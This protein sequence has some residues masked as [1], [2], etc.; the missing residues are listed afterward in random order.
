MIFLV[1]ID[2]ITYIT[3]GSGAEFMDMV[4]ISVVCVWLGEEKC[5]K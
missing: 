1:V 3:I 2:V 5:Q 4:I